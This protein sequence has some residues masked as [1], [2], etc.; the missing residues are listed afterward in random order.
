M[1]GANV[2][3]G[4]INISPI[5]RHHIGIGINDWVICLLNHFIK[6]E[7]QILNTFIIN[8][9][10]EDFDPKVQELARLVFKIGNQGSSLLLQ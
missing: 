9:L 5:L 4:D 2:G 3:L 6:K 1:N 10:L 7:I 8:I